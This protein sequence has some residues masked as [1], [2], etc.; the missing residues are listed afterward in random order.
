[1]TGTVDVAATHLLVWLKEL[2]KDDACSSANPYKG[3][4]GEISYQP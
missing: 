1:L 4:L 2:G 3:R